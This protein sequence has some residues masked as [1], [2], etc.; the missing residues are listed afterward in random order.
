MTAIYSRTPASAQ[1]L[2]DKL[3]IQPV[4]SAAEAARSACLTFLTVP[5]DAI[6]PVCEALA[7][8]QDLAG[9]AGWGL[10]CL[11]RCIGEDTR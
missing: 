3:G 6:I 7:R 1:R 9:R 10:R 11:K 2:A 4:E 5:D 8:D